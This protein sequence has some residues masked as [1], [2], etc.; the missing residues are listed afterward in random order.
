MEA[1]ECGM[2]KAYSEDR[3]SYN[4][5]LQSLLKSNRRA[6]VK[7]I[8]DGIDAEGKSLAPDTVHI[9]LTDA[10]SRRDMA[11]VDLLFSQ[12]FISG[13]TAPTL[14]SFNIMIEG[15][16][17]QGD[18]TRA[19]E[20][21]EIMEAQYS[22]VPDLYTYSSLIR[23]STTEDDIKGIVERA[24]RNMKVTPPVV[25]CAVE[26]LGKLGCPSAALS[27]SLQ[28]LSSGN[29]SIYA[30]SR[31]GDTLIT[32]FLYEQSFDREVNLPTDSNCTRSEIMSRCVRA[33]TAAFALAGVVDENAT[34]IPAPISIGSKG[35]CLLFSHLYGLAESSASAGNLQ[36]SNQLGQTM[37]RR[38]EKLWTL[39]RTSLVKSEA[40]RLLSSPVPV[41]NVAVSDGSNG[42]GPTEPLL[43]NGRLSYAVLRCYSQD[44]DTARTLWKRQLL[45]LASLTDKWAPG[46]ML[47][48]SEKSME[49]L[50]FSC[51][52]CGRPDIGLEIAITVRKRKWPKAQ[53]I[54]LSRKYFEGR[55]R[56]KA[57]GLA[58]M[59]TMANR[60][61]ETS[62]MSEL[63]AFDEG[64]LERAGKGIRLRTIRIRF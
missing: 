52:S 13:R 5:A 22:L 25:R 45:P 46:S 42:D 6:D 21:F 62:L 51:G 11:A 60:G 14:R 26:S 8:L 32:A 16:R 31:S 54:A 48:I 18:V 41:S 43:L 35:Y 20:L 27:V 37:S 47:E 49:A 30:S 57:T 1:L 24:A 28:Y 40:S 53:M 58:E 38:R 39:L 56:A 61:L 55:T 59:T 44:V 17:V 64:E 12:H 9:L 23:M 19:K 36:K 34:S 50:M 4:I 3:I 29:D 10:F 15:Y 2:L 63:G 33:D 7:R